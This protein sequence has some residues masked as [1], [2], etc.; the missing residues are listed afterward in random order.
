[1][2]LRSGLVAIAIGATT[3]AALPASASTGYMTF[4]LAATQSWIVDGFGVAV[5]DSFQG[6]VSCV[7]TGGS[8]TG[9]AIYGTCSVGSSTEYVAGTYSRV[10]SVATVSAN[11]GPGPIVGTLTGTCVVNVDAPPNLYYD[12]NCHF[13]VS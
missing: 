2:K 6:T 12:E 3:Y 1:M 9:G 10:G 13:V 11:I 4:Q 8:G 5:T 7:W